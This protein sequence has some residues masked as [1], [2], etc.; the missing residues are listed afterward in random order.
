MYVRDLSKFPKQDQVEERRYEIE[1]M[2]NPEKQKQILLTWAE[3]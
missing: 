1:K 2:E 3:E